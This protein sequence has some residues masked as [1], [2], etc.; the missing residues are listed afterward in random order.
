MHIK[1]RPTLYARS[2]F[3][4]IGIILNLALAISTRA[5]TLTVTS[6]ADSGGAWEFAE[7]AAP[8]VRTKT[9]K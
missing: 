4:V 7:C 5:T 8:S 3:I 1:R 2:R 9:R 6:T